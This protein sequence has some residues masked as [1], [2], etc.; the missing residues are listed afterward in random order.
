MA[1]VA[2]G[3][4]VLLAVGYILLQMGGSVD[5]SASGGVQRL[6]QAIATAEGFYVAGSRPQRNHNPGD[7]TQDLIGKAIAK[8]GFFVVYANDADGWANLYAQINLWLSGGS[9]HANAQST[10]SD[11]SGFYTTDNQS[12][13]AINVANS[14]GVTVDTPISVFEG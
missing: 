9:S 14:A 10:I 6:A 4:M 8:D 12:T 11:L 2:I 13:W 3:V 5:S 1:G 7:M